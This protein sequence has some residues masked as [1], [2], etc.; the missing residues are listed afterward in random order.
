MSDRFTTSPSARART[1][2][3]RL[4]CHLDAT[5]PGK[6]IGRL[7]DVL[8]GGLD[9]LTTQLGRVRRAH[10]LGH[11]DELADLLQL[12]ALH[13]LGANDFTLLT[14]RIERL[15]IVVA[16]HHEGDDEARATLTQ[17]LALP[18]D[19]SFDA[20]LEHRFE[21]DLVRRRVRRTIDLHHAGGT[22]GALLGA[23]ANLLDLELLDIT[24]PDDEGFW[25]VGTCRDRFHTAEQTPRVTTDLIALE[26]NPL[27]LEE[28]DATPYPHAQRFGFLRAGFG[29]VPVAVIVTGID[30]H[31]GGPMVVHTTSGVGVGFD[32]RVPADS[33]LV[34]STDGRVTLDGED[35]SER[36][37]GVAGAVYAEGPPRPTSTDQD[38]LFADAEQPSPSDAVFSVITPFDAE[39][40]PTLPQLQVG[41]NRWAFFV[42]IA[43]FGTVDDTLDD[44]NQEVG[45]LPFF[46]AGSWDR[47]H[48]ASH[49][50]SS[51]PKA[52][53]VGLR[54]HER[55]PFAVRVWLPER[56]TVLD[57]ADE[58]PVR[59]HVRTKLRRH[60]AAGIHVYTAYADDQWTLEQGRL[61]RDGG[62]WGFEDIVLGTRL[63]PDG[64][65]QPES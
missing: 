60:A 62:A 48:F 17:L 64:T 37:Y 53:K 3:A 45:A 24:H 43:H 7:T 54:W 25:H 4:P 44:D 16:A 26:E 21:L 47:S 50:E 39:P 27:R 9:P 59:E 63:W 31:T 11:A 13:G 22:I 6:T 55:E 2:L 52:G 61:P 40:P 33:E 57:V 14:R 38:F 8:A 58:I 29:P 34:F 41:E 30:E 35:V 15:R 20:L 18:V 51:K 10:R 28:L 49:D 12:G 65:S 56:L 46:A 1:V 42:Q 36:A 19:E 23:T 5:A 32:D